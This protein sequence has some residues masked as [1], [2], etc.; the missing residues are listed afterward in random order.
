M[1]RE[2]QRECDPHVA[3]SSFAPQGVAFQERVNN[4]S[5]LLKAG[6]GAVTSHRCNMC[7]RVI[8]SSQTSGTTLTPSRPNSLEGAN[9]S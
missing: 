3:H 8:Y 9:S 6:V 7:L 2:D 1:D 5:P 4:P